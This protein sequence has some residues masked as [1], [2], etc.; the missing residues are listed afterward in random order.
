MSLGKKVE[1]CSNII[2]KANISI[3][4]GRWILD[5]IGKVLSRIHACSL[6]KKCIAMEKACMISMHRSTTMF[7]GKCWKKCGET[8]KCRVVSCFGNISKQLYLRGCIMM[9]LDSLDCWT[10]MD[11]PY[12]LASLPRAMFRA[13]P[14]ILQTLDNLEPIGHA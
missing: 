5:D 12:L 3:K 9:Y 8:P 13:A 7:L 10:M 4:D 6:M 1:T 2:F 14:A 11:Q